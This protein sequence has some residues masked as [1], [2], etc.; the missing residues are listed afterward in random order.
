MANQSAYARWRERKLANAPRCA[1]ELLV[2]IRNPRAL[3]AAE[4]DA[5]LGHCRVANMALYEILNDDGADKG[6]IAALGAQF[7]LRRL[8]NNL[9]ADED[10]ITSLR[11]MP[12]GRHAAYIP[13]SN[14]RLSWH[15]DGYYNPPQQQIRAIL[16]HCVVPAARGGENHF[17]DHELLYI[18]LRDQD[19]EFIS[20]LMHPMA[21]TIPANVEQGEQ[22]RE[23]QSG[24]V[25]ALDARGNLHM[26]YTA[27]TRSIQWRDDPTTQAAARAIRDILEGDPP[28]LIRHRL[29]AGQGIISNNVLHN[30]TG[31]EDGDT[32]DRQRLLYRARYYDRIAQT[33]VV[34]GAQ[35]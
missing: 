31:F 3:D 22:V 6:A 20:A 17:L 9:C 2:R 33:D 8:D 10:S 19:P 23:A 35:S 24:P 4:Y 29:A 13:Y 30:R 21:M 5:I 14:R 15:T 26:R 16:M 12:S 25:F 18:Y 32:E 27:R 34:H 28:H 11:V 7:G 1:D